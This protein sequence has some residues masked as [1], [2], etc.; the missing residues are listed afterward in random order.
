MSVSRK[1]EWMCFAECMPIYCFYLCSFTFNVWEINILRKAWFVFIPL[2]SQGDRE[3]GAEQSWKWDWRRAEFLN[4]S[5]SCRWTEQHTEHCTGKQM[6]TCNQIKV[7]PGCQGSFLVSLLQCCY[8]AGRCKCHTHASTQLCIV[9][10]SEASPLCV[11][12]QNVFLLFNAFTT[13]RNSW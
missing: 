7:F 13:Q 4:S 3:A 5:I 12:M 11:S 2:P 8:C 10:L 1:L 9:N 6:F